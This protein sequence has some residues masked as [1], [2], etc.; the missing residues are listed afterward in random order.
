ME[1]F[2]M[3][4]LTCKI[5]DFKSDNLV[6]H[7][8]SK[9]RAD[10]G[11]LS[12]IMA[13]NSCSE[14][15]AVLISYMVKFNVDESD[16]VH[17]EADEPKEPKVESTGMIE[18][19]GV[20]FKAGRG[21]AEVP[22]I[23]PTYFFGPMSKEIAQDI[24][25]NRRIGLTGHTGCGKTSMIMQIAARIGQPCIRV[26]MNNQTT[27]SDF[28]GTWV[29]KGGSMEWIDGALPHALRLGYWL[30][31]DEIDCAEAGILSALNS[32]LERDG[33]L[34]LK[35]K[36]FEVIK[37]HADFRIFC[38]GNTLGSMSRFRHLYQGRNIMDEAFLDRW[39]VYKVDYL[40]PEEEARVLF[41][42]VPKNTLKIATIAV[43]VANMVRKAFKEET[44]QCTFSLRRLIDWSE[45]MIRYKD[46]LKA[47][48]TSIFS[49]VTDEDAEV[50]KGIIQHVM[51]GNNP[52]K[53]ETSKATF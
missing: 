31:V 11:D 46:P 15:E 20:K 36:G 50:I 34:T 30:I 4:R 25:E 51:V 1:V 17:P 33:H 42:A 22:S 39:R 12:A 13:D 37:P 27:I 21:G 43:R 14:K 28:V 35:E 40:T 41:E 9:H 18:V 48:E 23:D 6:P 47:A 38:T 26:N 24:T 49:K 52:K 10:F 2:F 45:L 53:P 3:K 32:V 7:I 5:C 44:V 29:A 8:E 16:V 19:A